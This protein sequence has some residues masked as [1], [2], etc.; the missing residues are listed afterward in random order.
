MMDS[1]WCQQR[2]VIFDDP[3]QENKDLEDHLILGLDPATDFIWSIH[4]V[5]DLPDFL[6][7]YTSLHNDSLYTVSTCSCHVAKTAMHLL[8]MRYKRHVWSWIDLLK[9]NIIS[10]LHDPNDVAHPTPTP[11]FKWTNPFFFIRLG[12]WPSFSSISGYGNDKCWNRASFCCFCDALYPP[13]LILSIIST[14]ADLVIAKRLLISAEHPPL[15]V[16]SDPRKLN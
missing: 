7:P 12:E 6:L 10:S 16:I 13:Y 3:W 5:L 8:W 1:L 9:Y 2:H 11:Q 4:P 14:I 15:V